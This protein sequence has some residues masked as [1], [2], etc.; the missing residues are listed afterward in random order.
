MSNKI[1]IEKLQSVYD[2]LKL[3]VKI[4]LPIA[5]ITLVGIELFGYYNL[6]LSVNEYTS[7]HAITG[8]FIF[9]AV[10]IFGGASLV[11]SLIIGVFVL[12]FARQN[13]MRKSLRKKFL[14]IVGILLSGPLVIIFTAGL[15]F[16][17]NSISFSSDIILLTWLPL[18]VMKIL[19]WFLKKAIDCSVSINDKSE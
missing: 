12:A 13:F 7:K 8:E 4:Y 18:F 3:A 1:K 11:I 19:Q 17:E 5:I 6:V 10:K 9:S 2:K 14:T 15:V 16:T